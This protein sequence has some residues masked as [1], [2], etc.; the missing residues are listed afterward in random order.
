MR[1]KAATLIVSLALS[2]LAAPLGVLK[3]A[4][5]LGLTIPPTILLRAD[6]VIR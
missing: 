4:R 1:H 5:A 2:F 3:A 6:H